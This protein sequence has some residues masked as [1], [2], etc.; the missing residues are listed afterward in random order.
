MN[1]L[2]NAMIKGFSNPIV[3]R[4]VMCGEAMFGS[5]GLKVSCEILIEVL[6]PSIRT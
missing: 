1:V 2:E 6:P 4:G 3:L 5:L